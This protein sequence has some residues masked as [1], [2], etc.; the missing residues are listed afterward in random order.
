METTALDQT[1][2]FVG[3]FADGWRIGA[4]HPQRFFEHF[5]R[6]LTPD[7]VLI[8]PLTPVRRGPRGLRQVFTPLFRIM[9]DLRGEVVRWGATDDGVLIELALRG[10]L[11]GRAVAW[12]T[13]DRI[14]L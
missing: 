11:S 13:V 1:A 2:E 8:Q 7:A 9:P 10:T 12:T 6:R 3:Y 5:D 4:T 14:V